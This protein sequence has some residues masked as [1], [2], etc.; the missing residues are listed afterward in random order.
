MVVV[1]VVVVVSVVVTTIAPPAV[2][3]GI[4]TRGVRKPRG[5]LAQPGLTPSP[6]EH[7]TSRTSGHLVVVMCLL[8]SGHSA[9]RGLKK[10]GRVERGASEQGLERRRLAAGAVKCGRLGVLLAFGHRI[11]ARPASCAE[12]A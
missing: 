9:R 3:I 12:R 10:L 6:R 1:V 11:E 5:R 7:Y 2:S 4:Y 8:Q